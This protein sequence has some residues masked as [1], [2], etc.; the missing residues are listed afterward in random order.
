MI[1]RLLSLSLLSRTALSEST[2]ARIC[3][4]PRILPM[5]LKPSSAAALELSMLPPVHSKLQGEVGRRVS[6]RVS[7]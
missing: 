3:K 6:K 1:K 2:V 4:L 5:M 7:R